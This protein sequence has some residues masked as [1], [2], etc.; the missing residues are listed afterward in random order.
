[1]I[2]A[3]T[4]I[5]P[6][7]QIIQTILDIEDEDTLITLLYACRTFEEILIKKQVNKWTDHWNFTVRYYLTKDDPD[8]VQKKKMYN[9]RILCH[10]I[11]HTD[12][13][14][15]VDAVDISKSCA[16]ICG[17]PSFENDM[18]SI[19]LQN[20]FTRERIIHF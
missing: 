13:V 19:L 10:R 7:A 6:M 5:T 2:A 16:F 9:D 20:H 1:M 4:G 17:P 8:A 12:I 11:C 15:I 18:E 14:D 3:G